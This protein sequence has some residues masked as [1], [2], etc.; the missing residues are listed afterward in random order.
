MHFR[1]LKMIVTSGFLTATNCTKFVFGWA[2]RPEPHWGS[3]QRSPDSLAGLRG[4]T[5][6]RGERKGRKRIRADGRKWRKSGKEKENEKG[7]PPLS[8]RTF[9]N[10]TTPL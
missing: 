2:L 4:P 1:I 6:K 7:G 10:V 8:R 9:L 3:L 5:S